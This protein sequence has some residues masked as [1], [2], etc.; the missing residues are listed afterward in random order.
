MSA[1]RFEYSEDARKALDRLEC[2]AGNRLWDDL[3]GAI[4]LIVTHPDSREARG[5]Q[6]R[7]RDDRAVW[8]VDVFDGS[9]DWAVLWHHNASNRVVIAW[10]G[11]WPPA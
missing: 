4:E 11:L 9:D 3:C 6:L 8:K 5:E 10:I 1:P 7:G 2:E